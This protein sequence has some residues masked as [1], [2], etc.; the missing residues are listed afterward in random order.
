MSYTAEDINRLLASP[1]E[2][3]RLEFKEAKE[4]F[5][6]RELSKYCVALANEGGGV[7]LLGVTDKAPRAVVGTNAFL[8][9]N[10]LKSD[11]FAKLKFRVDVEEIA[12]PLNL[13]KSTQT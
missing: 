2:H 1:H 8:N 5:D 12:V 3:E 7:L 13:C 10:E 11:I 4:Q 9:L 6:T